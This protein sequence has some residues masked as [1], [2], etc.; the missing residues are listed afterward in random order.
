MIN[1]P[2]SYKEA[3]ERVVELSPEIRSVLRLFGDQFSLLR[4]FDSALRALSAL[5]VRTVEGWVVRGPAS[6]F[7][8]FDENEAEKWGENGRVEQCAILLHDEETRK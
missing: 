3:V 8:V 6:S 7:V 4:D 2:K 5:K 1:D